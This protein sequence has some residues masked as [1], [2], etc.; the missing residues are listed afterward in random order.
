MHPA[1]S[2]PGVIWPC[3]SNQNP[4]LTDLRDPLNHPG[5]SS[6][7]LVSEVARLYRRTHAGANNRWSWQLAP[8]GLP[9]PGDIQDSAFHSR[10][11]GAV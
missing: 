9:I 1:G 5:G 10:V 11:A 8:S 2:A 6:R 7:L 3:W 4:A